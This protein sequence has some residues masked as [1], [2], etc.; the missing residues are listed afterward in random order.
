[1]VIPAKW[2]GIT[3]KQQPRL[4]FDDLEPITRLQNDTDKNGT[5]D[6]RD[7]AKESLGTTTLSQLKNTPVDEE[8]QRRLDDP[9]N[10]TAS[11]S[12]NLY[13]T[14][15]YLDKNKDVDAA[16]KKEMTEGLIAQEKA[17][18]VVTEYTNDD[19][20]LAKTEST[21]T[22]RAYGNAL[23]LLLKKAMDAKLLDGD[24]SIIETYVKTKD[25]SLLTSFTI[26]RDKT[27]ELIESLRA[28]PVPISAAPYH[29]LATNRLSEYYTILDGLSKTASDPVRGSIA[30]AEYL[31]TFKSLAGALN[32]MKGYFKAED[33]TFTQSEPGYVFSVGYTTSN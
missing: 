1:M 25:A 4:T 7:L 22:R 20:N 19:L 17:K 24:I 28:M 13:V 21:S 8:R 33:I 9:N 29:L 30:F 2:F 23:A 16:T 14:T 27:H 3:P 12:K 18:I 11:F 32:N 26:K 31:D 15:L 10:L 6:W 5:P